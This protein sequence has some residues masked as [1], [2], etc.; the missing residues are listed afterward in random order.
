MTRTSKQVGRAPPRRKPPAKG[1]KLVPLA[2]FRRGRF[3]GLL[4]GL[5]SDLRDVM[6]PNTA[7]NLRESKRNVLKDFVS[8]SGPL[9][10]TH[11]LI[12]SATQHASYLRVAKTPRG[13]TLTCRIQAYSRVSDVQAAQRKPRFPRTG[14]AACP[15]LRPRPFQAAPR[16]LEYLSSRPAPQRFGRA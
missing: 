11:F 4:K 13:P 3:G 7:L 14:E 12:L 15:A 6:R 9:G 5:E 10:V 2:V 16:A 1:P 8:V